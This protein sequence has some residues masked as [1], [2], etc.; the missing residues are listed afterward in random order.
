MT[1]WHL[2]LIAPSPVPFTSS[3]SDR[4][5]LLM[6]KDRS[7]ASLGTTMGGRSGC[8]GTSTSFFASSACGGGRSL[9]GS[10]SVPEFLRGIPGCLGD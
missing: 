9:F 2:Q 3:I 8:L 10:G 5:P 6:K 1:L 7:L 4:L